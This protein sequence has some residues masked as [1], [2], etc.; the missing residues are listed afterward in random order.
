MKKNKLQ[1]MVNY[2]NFKQKKKNKTKGEVLSSWDIWK[3]KIWKI[4]KHQKASTL[5]F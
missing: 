2:K 5:N 1:E 3:K 4:F